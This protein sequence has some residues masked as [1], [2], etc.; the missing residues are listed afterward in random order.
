M[1]KYG[2]YEVF[3]NIKTNEIKRIPYEETT[4]LE[5]LAEDG[6][7]HLDHDPQDMGIEDLAANDRKRWGG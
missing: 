4:D 1:E 2:T 5:K 3:R 6:W 7:E